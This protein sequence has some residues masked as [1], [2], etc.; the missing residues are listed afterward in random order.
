MRQVLG[1]KKVAVAVTRWVGEDL[2]GGGRV[3]RSVPDGEKIATVELVVDV[4][5]LLE[6]LGPRAIRSRG[7]RSRDAG[8]AVEVRV[9]GQIERRP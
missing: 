5:A 9:V 8:G 2:H 4:D 6:D 1:R 7:K 3:G